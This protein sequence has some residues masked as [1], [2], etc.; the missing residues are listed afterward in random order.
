MVTSDVRYFT[1]K[2][3]VKSVARNQK[4]LGQGRNEES[5]KK[6]KKQNEKSSDEQVI[7]VLTIDVSCVDVLDAHL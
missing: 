2:M 7:G 6:D 4:E 3:G 5:Q 1:Q